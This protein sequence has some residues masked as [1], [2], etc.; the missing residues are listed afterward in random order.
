MLFRSVQ[1]KLDEETAKDHSLW[2]C[3]F[4]VFRSLRTSTV[5]AQADW[6]QAPLTIDVMPAPEFVSVLWKNLSIGLFERFGHVT[7]RYLKLITLAEAQP[8]W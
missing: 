8:S 1:A 5:A 6:D 3:S 7:Q 4:V 2:P